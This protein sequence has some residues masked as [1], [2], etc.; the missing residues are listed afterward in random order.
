MTDKTIDLNDVFEE[1]EEFFNEHYS[2]QPDDAAHSEFEEIRFQ[3]F[4]QTEN[5]QRSDYQP[6][7]K[8]V[9]ESEDSLD[10]FFWFRQ[11]RP[12]YKFSFYRDC[13]KAGIEK[14]LMKRFVV[15]VQTGLYDGHKNRNSNDALAIK[16]SVYDYVV[17]KNQGAIQFN[18]SQPSSPPFFS[19]N[20]LE[21][22]LSINKSLIH[23][24]FSDWLSE[25]KLEK[26]TNDIVFR[27][28]LHSAKE[29]DVDNYAEREIIIC[30]SLSITVAEKFAKINNNIG[31][32]PHIIR[33]DYNASMGNIL[34]TSLIIE[35]PNSSIEQYEFGV[36]PL[37][38]DKIEYLEEYM[39][40]HEYKIKWQ[41]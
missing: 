9:D 31:E 18:A 20:E 24:M 10:K 37:I 21:T 14:C 32:I 17:S 33:V 19:R 30:Q 7:D 35:N 26:S 15:A 34:Y 28:G 22:I 25:N 4:A 13:L 23:L 38:Y 12:K 39:G 36:I 41:P 29:I 11:R 1:T 2:N 8:T 16:R 5:V 40:M 6:G 3:Q 27:R